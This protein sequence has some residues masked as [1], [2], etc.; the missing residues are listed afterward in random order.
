MRSGLARRALA[1]PAVNQC[2]CIGGFYLDV[3]PPA[4]PAHPYGGTDS[5]DAPS[6]NPTTGQAFYRYGL[7]GKCKATN[8]NTVRVCRC[9]CADNQYGMS[10]NCS[11]CPA[12]SLSSFQAPDRSSCMCN[13]GY[14]LNASE[15][16][17]SPCPGGTYARRMEFVEQDFG[18]DG[19]VGW[20]GT[21]QTSSCGAYGS[22][23]G[24]L[25]VLAEYSSVTKTF[26]GLCPHG[27][28]YLWMRVVLIDVAQPVTLRMYVNRQLRMYVNRQLR[29]YVNRQLRMYVNR[30]EVWNETISA[31]FPVSSRCGSSNGDGLISGF[32]RLYHTEDYIE[33]GIRVDYDYLQVDASIAK[34]FWG[35]KEVSLI[36]QC[37]SSTS[38]DCS[39]TKPLEQSCSDVTGSGGRCTR[40]GNYLL[41]C[42]LLQ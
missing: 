20:Q 1:T 37:A 41:V 26:T 15:G 17:C 9:T 35:L 3:G 24:G 8:A 23:L 33:V 12:N 29:M 25:N 39:M 21:D 18:K 13:F 28:V 10:G 19:I 34:T 30:Q 27:F 11:S 42:P 40:S 38:A 22:V 6:Y 36:L 14:F 31:V 16:G 2:Q 4:P 5:V 7:P 32:K